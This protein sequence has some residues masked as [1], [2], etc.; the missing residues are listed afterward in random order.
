MADYESMGRFC[1]K[2]ER[3][4]ELERL[5]TGEGQNPIANSVM[6]PFYQQE[7]NRLVGAVNSYL[8]RTYSGNLI[9]LALDVHAYMQ[10]LQNERVEEIRVEH[11]QKV[12]EERKSNEEFAA[13]VDKFAKDCAEINA[14]LNKPK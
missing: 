11:A 6:L 9:S 12:E 13:L 7:H 1:S 8:A 5:M 3:I 10:E 2:L 4:S 14:R